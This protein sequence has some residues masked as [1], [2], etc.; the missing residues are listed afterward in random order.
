[1]D[2]E[3]ITAGVRL[4]GLNDRTEIKILICY[5][6]NA[7]N[8]PITQNQLIECICGQELVNYFEMQ[9]AISRL[10]EQKL[11]RE[12][13]NGFTIT[14]EGTKV[15]TQLEDVVSATVKRYAYSVAVKLLQYDALKKQNKTRITPL[16]DGGFNLKCSIE[17]DNFVIFEMDIHMPDEKTAKFAGEQFILMGQDIF[18]CM[19]GIV[20][21]SPKM[22]KD[23]LN[24]DK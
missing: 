21:D 5:L 19:L 13:E 16:P 11:I 24:K 9:N 14:E 12:D 20:T 17:D 22:Y 23:I 10:L 18:K 4:G 3:A 15:A 8:R 6:L 7:L 2:N 1:M